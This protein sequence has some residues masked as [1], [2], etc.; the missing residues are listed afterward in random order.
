MEKDKISAVIE[1]PEP[2][3]VKSLQCFVSFANFYRCFIMGYR[4]V[5]AQP[6]DLLKGGKKW[7]VQFTLRARAVFAELKKR[8]MSAPILKM[9]KLLFPLPYR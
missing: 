2:T 5:A 4:V 8:S 6:M 7:R 1:W 9:P 3:T